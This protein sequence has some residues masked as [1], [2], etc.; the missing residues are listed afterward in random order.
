MFGRATAAAKDFCRQYDEF[1]KASTLNAELLNKLTITRDEIALTT[2][3]PQEKPA[4]AAQLVDLK[5]K[6]CGAVL[7][8]DKNKNLVECPYC[9]SKYMVVRGVDN[10]LEDWVEEEILSL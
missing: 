4:A 2:W 7:N 1:V 5:C 3:V 8:I 9:N 10:V 6:N